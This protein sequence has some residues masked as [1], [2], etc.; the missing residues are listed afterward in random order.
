MGGTNLQMKAFENI[1]TSYTSK[2]D[3]AA[4]IQRK[5]MAM[6]HTTRGHAVAIT[7]LDWFRS[8]NGPAMAS[9]QAEGWE[10][11]ISNWS[12]GTSR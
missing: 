12:K 4:N 7:K 1:D 2:L 6:L 8:S 10:C 11:Q 9:K 3:V 5:L